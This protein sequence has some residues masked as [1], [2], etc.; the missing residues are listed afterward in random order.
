MQVPDLK[1]GFPKEMALAGVKRE[2]LSEPKVLFGPAGEA[3]F[4]L[5]V[6]R[7]ILRLSPKGTLAEVPAKFQA[8]PM[9]AVFTAY[10]K[11]LLVI[12]IEGKLYQVSIPK[13]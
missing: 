2:A 8:F 10:G 6:T 5:P 4:V 9:D 7:Q 3:F 13:T 11:E 12:D 1:G